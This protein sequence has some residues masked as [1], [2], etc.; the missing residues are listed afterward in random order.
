MKG[1]VSELKILTDDET[2]III[3]ESTH[4]IIDITIYYP[5]GKYVMMNIEEL[6]EALYEHGY[7]KGGN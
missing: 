5:N 1:D 7:A 6:A 4:S 2:R 3:S